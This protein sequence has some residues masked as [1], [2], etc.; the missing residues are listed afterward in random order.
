M[1]RSMTSGACSPRSKSRNDRE[2]GYWQ[3]TPVGA[4]ITRCTLLNVNAQIAI[5][6]KHVGNDC[7]ICKLETWKTE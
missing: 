2:Q 4:N 7:C 3:G 5:C 6:N 1:V